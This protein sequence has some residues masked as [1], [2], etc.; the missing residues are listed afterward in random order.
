[1]RRPLPGL[2][3]QCNSRRALENKLRQGFPLTYP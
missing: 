2:K 3:F 1:M